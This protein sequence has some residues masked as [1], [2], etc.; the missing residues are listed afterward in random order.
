MSGEMGPTVQRNAP[1]GLTPWLVWSVAVAFVLY[2][3]GF[4]TGYS[5]ANPGIQKEVGLTVSQVGLIAATYTWSFAFFQMF[6]GALLDRLG[7]RAVLLPA[8]SLVTVGVFVFAHAASFEAIIAAQ[9]ILA[10]G[11]CAGFVG[12]GYVGG[13]WFGMAKFSLMFGLVQ[14]L[15]S[16][17]SAVNQNLLA[18]AL[19]NLEWRE[20]FTWAGFVGIAILVLAFVFIRNPAPIASAGTSQSVI[21][22][23]T[24]LLSGILRVARVRHVWIAAGY[25]ALIFG[26]LL[27]AGVVWAPKL[28]LARGLPAIAANFAASVLWFGMAAGC[29]VLPWWSEAVGRRKLPVLSGIAMQLGALLG[30]IYLPPISSTV[31]MELWFVFGFGAAAH[32]LA[33]SAAGD[34]VKL[35]QLGTCAAIVNGTM[36]LVSG[37]HIARPGK[38]AARLIDSGAPEA[39]T[40]AQ[41]ALRPLALGLAVALVLAAVIRE[42][43]PK[44]S[45]NR[46]AI[47]WG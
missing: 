14:C 40:L 20:L 21:R 12:A 7:A 36:F 10:L 6:S 17:F 13:Q 38:I 3:F 27:A 5:V 28:M 15:A 25:G 26:A 11:A 4:Q 43:H 16:L 29:I 34:A 8:I 2:L 9:L 46:L 32:M 33:F 45:G 31:A 22:F 18:V 30:L 44:A 39:M 24:E 37:L 1:V 41:M 42:S 23:L 19:R 47:D 35:E